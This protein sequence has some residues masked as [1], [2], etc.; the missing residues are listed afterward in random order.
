MTNLLLHL[1]S[2]PSL[3]YAAL[4]LGAM[5]IFLGAALVST[6][7]NPNRS[8]REQILHDGEVREIHRDRERR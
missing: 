7:L 6:L 3:Q 4:V 1:I 8:R 2:N 5:G